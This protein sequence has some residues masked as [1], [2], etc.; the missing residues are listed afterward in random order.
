MSDE[1]SDPGPRA[2]LAEPFTVGD[3]LAE[4]AWNRIRRAQDSVKL[5]PR[6]MRLLATLAA[7]PGRP[8]GRDQ[9]LDAVWPGVSVNEEALSR[10]ISQLRKCL[11]DDPRRP[12]FVE[13]VHKGGY[14]LVAPVRHPGEP[15]S[16]T[17]PVARGFRAARF[18]KMGLL[19]VALVLAGLAIAW[20]ASGRPPRPNAALVPVPVTSEPGREIDPAISADGRR[21]AFGASTEAGYDL[22]WRDIDGGRLVRL[23]RDGR[24]GGYPVWSPDGAR[25]AFL[26]TA[27]AGLSIDVVE[28]LGGKTGTIARLDTRSFGLDWSPDG[29][30]LAYSGGM[31]GQAPG[32]ILLDVA[33]RSRQT[34][35]RGPAAGGDGRPVFAPDGRRLAFLRDAGL[36][37]QRIFLVDLDDPEAPRPVTSQPEEIAGLDWDPAGRSLV[38]AAGTAGRFELRAVAAGGGASPREIPTTG[39]DL[40]NPSISSTGRLVAEAVE[41]DSD[42]WR[43][44]ID[45]TGA[46]PLIRSTFDDEDA[47]WSQDGRRIAFMSARSGSPEIWVAAADGGGARQVTHLGGPNVGGPIWSADGRLAFYVQREGYAATYVAGPGRRVALL[48]AGGRLHRIPLAWSETG[49]SLLIASG[50]GSS[51]SV[52]RHD[53]ASGRSTLVN[54]VAARLAAA[55]GDGRF[56]YLVTDDGARLMRVAAGSGRV[57][58]FPLPRAL[59]AANAMRAAGGSLYFFLFVEGGTAVHRFRAGG[60]PVFA[61]VARMPTFGRISIAPREDALLWAR[62][63]ETGNDIVLLDLPRG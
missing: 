47:A 10:A 24:F 8:L 60:A 55:S 46:A 22:F 18:A 62:Q 21:L 44:R 63:R 41:Q 42:I 30:T 25:L 51:W 35:T 38:Y 1:R 50:S 20:W 31:D 36:G 14:C 23:T 48:A 7:A 16:A 57:D 59:L 15:S 54:P 33:S 34:L 56:V 58:S 37:L 49:D 53:L 26:R 27:G 11:G 28:A 13:T 45:G 61:E 4:P 40:F 39:G 52:S 19:V 3:W 17:G 12:A 9:L 6:V 32:I 2:P 5:E 43:S 29:R